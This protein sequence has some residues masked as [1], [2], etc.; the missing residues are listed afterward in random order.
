MI[1]CCFENLVL[2]QDKCETVLKYTKNTK[3]L[4]CCE[5]KTVTSLLLLSIFLG[6]IC[7]SVFHSF[8]AKGALDTC[9]IV[10]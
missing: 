2:G 5:V 1:Q 10:F 3:W 8:F 9:K 4:L 7:S 6:C